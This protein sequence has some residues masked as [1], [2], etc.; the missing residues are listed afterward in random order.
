M[1]AADITL[2]KNVYLQATTTGT[3]LRISPK[4]K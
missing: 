1:E 3:F 4:H 2:K